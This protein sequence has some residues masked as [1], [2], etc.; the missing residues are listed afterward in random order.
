M[1]LAHPSPLR[2]RDASSSGD[3]LPLRSPGAL[4]STPH[5][6]SH[7]SPISFSLTLGGKL[8]IYGAPSDSGGAMRTQRQR[9]DRRALRGVTRARSLPDRGTEGRGGGGGGSLC[10]LPR[11]SSGRPRTKLRS[12][13]Q[14]IDPV[15][16]H[17]PRDQ[18]TSSNA[19]DSKPDTRDKMAGGAGDSRAVRAGS[20]DA[21]ARGP[22][23]RRSGRDGLGSAPRPP[24]G[25]AGVSART[26]PAAAGRARRRRRTRAASPAQPRPER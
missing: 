21:T 6:P 18:D 5:P 9:R 7:S 4:T 25:R 2:L 26:G 23:P 13:T 11:E 24:P 15:P 8:A 20:R 17:K 10:R 22:A 3:S 14:T 19:A 12:Q 1:A 16:C